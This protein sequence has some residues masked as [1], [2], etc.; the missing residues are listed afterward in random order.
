LAQIR[1]NK[2]HDHII[3]TVK[4]I[5]IIIYNIYKSIIFILHAPETSKT[6]KLIYTT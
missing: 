2:N 4:H 3:I 5:Y 1:K 6:T